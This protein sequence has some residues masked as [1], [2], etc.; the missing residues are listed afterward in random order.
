MK[1]STLAENILGDCK[2][3]WGEP[4][5]TPVMSHAYRDTKVPGLHQFHPP[6]CPSNVWTN[7]PV[8][9]FQM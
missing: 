1:S 4:E 5:H 8:W 7:S 3:L 2:T 6:V 9:R